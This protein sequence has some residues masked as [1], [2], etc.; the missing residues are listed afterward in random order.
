MP[1]RSRISSPSC[2]PV[3]VRLPE[4]SDTLRITLV[5]LADTAIGEVRGLDGAA[6]RERAVDVLAGLRDQVADIAGVQKKQAALSV[7]GAAAEGTVEV[8][9]DARGQVIKTVIDGSFLDDHDFEEL[10]DYVTEAAR[11]AA[12]DA[13]RQ[14]AQMMAPINERH[15]LFPSLS[16]IVEGLPDRGDLMP[17]GLDMCGAAPRS[18]EASSVSSTSGEGDGQGRTD[19]PTVR[20]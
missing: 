11:A 7:N 9:V 4:P 14:V 1:R 10:G 2:S 15:R 12:G 6:A 19:F 5:E 20:G 18:G 3:R 8:T 13:G 17:P 16:D